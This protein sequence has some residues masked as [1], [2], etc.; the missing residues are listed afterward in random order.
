MT[1]LGGTARLIKE[2]LFSPF[3]QLQR[4]CYQHA[5]LC[6][7][8][9]S[10]LT[11]S[12]TCKGKSCYDANNT[13]HFCPLYTFP[14]CIAPLADEQKHFCS[15]GS[16]IIVWD[17]QREAQDCVNHF[18]GPWLSDL[19]PEH[20]HIGLKIRLAGPYLSTRSRLGTL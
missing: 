16:H 3:T 4:T 18:G 14:T 19:C 13:C 20:G 8:D 17:V 6:Y 15:E 5:S 11:T 10:V 9:E 12:E 2:K 7:R 1:L